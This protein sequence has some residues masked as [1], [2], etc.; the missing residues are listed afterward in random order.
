M[1]KAEEARHSRNHLALRGKLELLGGLV[2]Y[3]NPPTGDVHLR[4]V[5]RKRLGKG[6]GVS[7]YLLPV[8]LG[9][10]LHSPLPIPVPPPVITTTLLLTEKSEL[11]EKSAVDM[12]SSRGSGFGSGMS[13][14]FDTV[15]G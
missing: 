3:V 10:S 14:V 13:Q 7:V 4:A 1:R 5:L 9:M 8:P 2:E 11:R 15:G 12:V 6:C